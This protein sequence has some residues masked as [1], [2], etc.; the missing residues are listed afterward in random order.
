[1]SWVMAGVAVVGGGI[2]MYQGYKQK[3]AGEAAEAQ[4]K[5]NRP[6]YKISTEAKQNLKDAEQMA[7]QGLASE[8]RT[9]AEQDI[10]RTTQAAMMGSADRRGGL[11]MVSSTAATEQRA[12]LG[13]LH[14]DVQAR[15]DNMATL[16]QVRD[17]MTGYKNQQF[18]HQYNEYA[19]DLDYARAQIGAGI[20]N[21]QQGTQD[22]IGG[23]GTGAQGMVGG[24]S[25]ARMAGGQ[26]G[27]PQMKQGGGFM[28]TRS[29]MAAARLEN[30]GLSS[31]GT[32]MSLVQ[33][34]TNSQKRNLFDPSGST[35][36]SQWSQ[37]GQQG[38]VGTYQ[39]G[40]GVGTQM[41]GGSPYSIGLDYSKFPND[42][43]T[44]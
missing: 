5:A 31:E 23:L 25:Q 18:E 8:Q 1:M 15:R 4:A 13:L 21:Q 24:M 6:E 43:K 12:N 38:S 37:F 27:A 42:G 33:D 28:G 41:F 14:K 22:I 39:P 35:K 40:V 2:K 44:Y 36:K 3:K 26:G 17:T 34:M 10:Q 7:A 29:P 32:Q 16:M 19:A 30:P 9:A 20:Q 11:G